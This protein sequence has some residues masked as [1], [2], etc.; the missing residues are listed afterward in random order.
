M[1]RN[2]AYQTTP[3]LIHSPFNTVIWKKICSRK[4]Q[5]CERPDNLSIVT[6]NSDIVV[7][8]FQREL[9]NH[10]IKVH[11]LGRGITNWYHSLKIKLLLKEIDQIK[12]PYILSADCFDVTINRNLISIVDDFK[13]QFQTVK[14]LFN[15]TT[16]NYPWLP[17]FINQPVRCNTM[18]C[19][20]NSG[21]WIGE[22]D[23]VRYFFEKTLTMMDTYWGFDDQV[24]AKRLYQTEYPH[25]Q[26]DEYCKLFQVIHIET[27]NTFE[28]QNKIFI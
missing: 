16:R 9:K 5:L 8:G 24:M 27:T 14:L 2:I 7:R 19:Y 3:Y 6:Y 10:N 11:V 12:T 1:F 28:I 26:I 18:F 13:S 25:T 15:A 23:Y 4:L 22:T 21:V 20:L 17:E